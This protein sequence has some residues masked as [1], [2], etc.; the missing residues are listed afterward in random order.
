LFALAVPSLDHLD[1]IRVAEIERVAAFLP[2]GARILDIGAGTGRQ[3]LE[4][5]RRGFT[6]TAIEIADSTYAAQRVFPVKDY[7]GR[8]IPLPDASVD[9][10]FSSNVLEHV[11]DLARMHA[12][13][14]R[15][16]APSGSCIHVLPTHS[17]RFWT[18]LTSYLK[19]VAF[20]ASSLPQLVPRAP[21]RA[22]ELRRLRQAW[23]RTARHAAG[24]C[25][26]R[27]HGERGNVVSEL[28][29]FHPRWWRRNFEEHGFA[30]VADE[31]MG[32]FYTGE[33]LLGLR[34]GLAERARLARV[35][36]SSCRLF[37]LVP[38]G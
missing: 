25:L 27:R 32:L 14:R 10:V 38:T 34:L 3:A 15:V 37:R 23:Y 13:I 1:A 22:A 36:G 35:L 33:E 2:A 5:Q 31:P 29:L 9:V 20:S 24:L 12:E 7:D 18:T 28:W 11:A 30:V 4:L 21:P 6:V 8:T 16:L 26:P 17:W 19:A